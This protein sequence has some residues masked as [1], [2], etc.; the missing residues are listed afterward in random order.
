VEYI[1]NGGEIMSVVHG[2]LA[3]KPL[4]EEAVSVR[5]HQEVVIRNVGDKKTPSKEALQRFTNLYIAAVKRN[6]HKFK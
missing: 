1:F 3:H 2:N 6:L 4:I 5:K